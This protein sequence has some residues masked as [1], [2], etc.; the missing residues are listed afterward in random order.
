[1]FQNGY[2]SNAVTLTDSGG[3]LVDSAVCAFQTLA[4]VQSNGTQVM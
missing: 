2:L 4:T 1:M 3:N